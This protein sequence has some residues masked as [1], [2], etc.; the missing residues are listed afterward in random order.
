MEIWQTKG[1]Q[2]YLNGNKIVFNDSMTLTQL[3]LETR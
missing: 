1:R 3:L 2:E